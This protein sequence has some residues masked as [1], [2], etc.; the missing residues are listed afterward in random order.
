MILLHLPRTYQVCNKALNEWELRVPQAFS[1]PSRKRYKSAITASKIHL[2]RAALQQQDHRVIQSRLFEEQ[3]AR[4]TNRKSLNYG[5]SLDIETARE[6]KRAKQQKKTDEAI[7]KARK[8]IEDATRKATKDLNRRGIDARR[9]ERER[10]KTIRSLV[11]EGEVM[12]PA[13]L[14]VAIRD[15]EKDPT[16]DDLESL[17]PHPSL[18][19]ALDDLLNQPL[20]DDVMHINPQLLVDEGLERQLQLRAEAIS[21]IED[22]ETSDEDEDSPL[23]DDQDGCLEICLQRTEEAIVAIEDTSDEL[24]D[25]DSTVLSDDESEI[26][27][28]GM[29]ILLGYVSF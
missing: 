18:V 15:P 24:E 5:G 14:Y 8:K 21:A 23:L 20:Q 11:A 22:R 25:E 16:A 10:K 1:S 29:P 7:R 28:H 17:R 12:V 13:E 19:Q 4:A 9:A 6:T 2:G 26:L 3:R 27:L